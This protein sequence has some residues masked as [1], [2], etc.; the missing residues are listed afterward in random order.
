MTMNDGYPVPIKQM[1]TDNGPAILA[2]VMSGFL[3]LD[4]AVLAIDSPTLLGAAAHSPEAF[5][6]GHQRD[7]HHNAPQPQTHGR[8]WGT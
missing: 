4:Q 6:Q 7:G 8:G 2:E 3:Q 1:F 5:R